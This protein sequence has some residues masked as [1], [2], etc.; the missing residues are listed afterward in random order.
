LQKL[1]DEV[2]FRFLFN[3]VP[4]TQSI[5]AVLILSLWSPIGGAAQAV[6][7]DGRLLI[8][9]GVSMAMNLRLSQ[10]VEYA[11]GLRDGTKRDECVLETIASDLEDATDKARLVCR[12]VLSA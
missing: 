9:S 11:A 3:P 2:I 4:S 5:L 10:A 1:T 8:A 12:T 7:Q 6:G